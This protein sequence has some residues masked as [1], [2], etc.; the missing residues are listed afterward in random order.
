MKR[1]EVLQKLHH[2]GMRGTDL[3]H[4]IESNPRTD[5][6]EAELREL[7]QAIQGELRDEYE[8][9]HADQW[10]NSLTV[11]EISVYS[12]TICRMWKDTVINGLDVHAEIGAKWQEVF[13]AII[14]LSR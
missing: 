13:A 12:P 11:F 7:A 10:T 8:R 4:R 3:L 2:I 9:M 5:E 6:A 14:H 1:H